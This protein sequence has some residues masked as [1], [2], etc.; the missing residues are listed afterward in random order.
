MQRAAFRKLRACAGVA[1]V[2]AHGL[3]AK[4]KE[5]VDAWVEELNGVDVRKFEVAARR[6]PLRSPLEEIKRKIKRYLEENRDERH[7]ELKSFLQELHSGGEGAAAPVA[8]PALEAPEAGD[9]E[10]PALPAAHPADAEPAAVDE[11]LQ[12]LR[13]EVRDRVEP[14]YPGAWHI[15]RRRVGTALWDPMNWSLEDLNDV[16]AALERR[17]HLAAGQVPASAAAHGAWPTLEEA[18][19]QVSPACSVYKSKADC[20]WPCAWK[21]GRVDRNKLCRPA[22]AA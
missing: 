13:R 16:K 6:R 3:G 17:D 1:E 19:H 14:L 2:S 9:D 11:A 10:E 5:N 21:S 18:H 22:R 7:A 20:V 15:A 4:C 8:A 12:A